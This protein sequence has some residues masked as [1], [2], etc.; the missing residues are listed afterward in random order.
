MKKKELHLEDKLS[1]AADKLRKG[2]YG[3]ART[4]E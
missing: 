3:T 4:I 1:K 2:D